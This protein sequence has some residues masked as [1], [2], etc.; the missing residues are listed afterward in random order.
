MGHP[1]P[2]LASVME[3]TGNLVNPVNPGA[4]PLAC[5]TYSTSLLY[6]YACHKESLV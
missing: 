6:M 5:A 4:N 2:G 3:Y 1:E